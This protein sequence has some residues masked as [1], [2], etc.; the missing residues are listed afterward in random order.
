MKEDARRN[1]RKRDR[2]KRRKEMKKYAAEKKAQAQPN[3]TDD[4]T[5]NAA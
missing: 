2:Q 4:L 1:R 3:K 5:S